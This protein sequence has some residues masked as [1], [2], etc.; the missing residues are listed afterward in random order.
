[1]TFKEPYTLRVDL[2]DFE[3]PESLI[4]TE[5]LAK[6]DGARMLVVDS[7]GAID[8]KLVVDLGCYLGAGD[9]LVV[10]NTKVMPARLFGRRGDAKIE[11]LLHQQVDGTHDGTQWKAFAKPA[12]KLKVGDTIILDAPATDAAPGAGGII[13]PCVVQVLDKLDDGQVLLDMQLP[14]AELMVC[15]DT[16]GH[17][18]L[19][20]YIQKHRGSKAVTGE[21]DKCRYQTVF[22]DEGKKRSVAAPTAGLH[23]TDE[24]L[25]QLISMG[26][27]VAQVTLH[28]GA[29]TFLPVKAD[30]TDE[31][32]MHSEQWEISPQA[33]KAINAAKA[34]GRRV[35]AVGTT[36]LRTLEGA[37]SL[38]MLTAGSGS[39]D[40]FITPGYKFQ[41]VDVLLTNFHLPKSTLFMLVSAFSGL[42]TMQTAYEHAKTQEYRFYS[43]GDACLLH[44]REEPL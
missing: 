7:S 13:P 34:D 33:A 29:G 17:M 18:P 16:H 40:I 21:D 26:V 15:L 42:D 22:S 36:S 23:F 6:R 37:A 24:L 30:N 20:P 25:K 31:H 8:D 35:I 2:F 3:L 9:V 41:M 10:N 12:K 32:T 28:V 27:E 14:F 5:P 11:L 43:Y 38:G 44:R 4:A 1:M 39:T 19:P